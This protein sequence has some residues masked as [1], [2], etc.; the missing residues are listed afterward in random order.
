[1]VF[2]GDKLVP[3]ASWKGASLGP[4]VRFGSIVQPLHFNSWLLIKLLLKGVVMTFLE[5]LHKLYTK[6]K[7]STVKAAHYSLHSRML[8]LH[9]RITKM[10]AQLLSIAPCLGCTALCA[11]LM[12]SNAEHFFS[13]GNDQQLGCTYTAAAKTS[14]AK[15]MQ[16]KQTHAD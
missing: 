9:G 5:A 11:G 16:D 8:M 12:T 4:E 13:S 3:L 2:S 14:S 6:T 15:L 1:M 7:S 10:G